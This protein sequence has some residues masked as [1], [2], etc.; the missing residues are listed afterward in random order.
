MS[1]SLFSFLKQA[2]A[3][4]FK[5]FH[6]YR[7]TL[8][9]HK[10]IGSSC[11]RIYRAGKNSSNKISMLWFIFHKPQDVVVPFRQESRYFFWNI[12]TMI[13][14]QRISKIRFADTLEGKILGKIIHLRATTAQ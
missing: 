6:T 14:L 9:W 8:Q 1:F 7:A 11:M 3:W 10:D 12:H 5:N 13:L 4:N 2:E